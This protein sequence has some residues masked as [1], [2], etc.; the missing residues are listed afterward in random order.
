MHCITL[1]SLF[2]IDLLDLEL[3]LESLSD[4]GC[5]LF[6][7]VDMF[8]FQLDWEFFLQRMHGVLSWLSRGGIR[9]LQART[10]SLGFLCLIR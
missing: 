2:F 1:V 7:Q 6:E 8:T 10:W 5:Q 4:W 9:D 3:N